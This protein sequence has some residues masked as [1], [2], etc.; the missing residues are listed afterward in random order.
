MPPMRSSD[1]FHEE[2]D[3]SPWGDGISTTVLDIDLVKTLRERSVEGHADASAG[4]G[5]LDLAQEE[6]EASGTGGGERLD[7]REIEEVLRAIEALT[8][9]LAVP[10]DVPFRNFKTFKSYWL[11]RRPRLV[12]DPP[13]HG[14]GD[15]RPDQAETDPSRGQRP[16]VLAL[17]DPR[18]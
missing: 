14:R 6:L 17:Q 4:L 3:H 5:L 12:A 9:R 8:I 1:F 16:A 2:I 13:R 11:K 18:R 7:D 15:L 10:I